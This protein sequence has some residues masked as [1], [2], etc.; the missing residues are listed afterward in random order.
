M[1]TAAYLATRKK[2]A[3]PQAMIFADAY[4]LDGSKY[5]PAGTE[6]QDFIV[7][8]D[9]NRRDLSLKPDRIEQRKR[10]IN[11]RMRSVWLADKLK[12]STSWQDFPSR[13]AANGLSVVGQDVVASGNLYIV[14]KGASASELAKW[15]R[16]HTGSFWVLISFDDPTL[17]SGYDKLTEYTIAIECMFSNFDATVSKRGGI[18]DLWNVS[19]EVEE[20]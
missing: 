20:V 4:T 8:S 6:F 7:L 12:V 2:Y 14:D 13:S 9:H 1:A 15:H 17:L 5:V 18:M 10:M 3:R 16:D 19:L 11:G